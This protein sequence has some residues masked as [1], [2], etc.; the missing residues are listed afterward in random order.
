MARTGRPKKYQVDIAEV[1]KL[2]SFGCTNK[3]IADFFSCPENSFNATYSR[4][5]SKGRSELKK[6]LRK[7][8]INLALSG[9]ATMLIWLGK[10]YLEQSD[11]NE[12]G[13]NDSFTEVAKSFAQMVQIAGAGRVSSGDRSIPE[14][15]DKI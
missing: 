13:I 2:A 10:Q 12:I 6:R 7:A 4:H 11:K 8:Q 14:R 5:T 3:E 15:S 9:N 1:E